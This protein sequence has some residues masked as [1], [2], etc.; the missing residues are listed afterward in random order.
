MCIVS[1]AV[2]KLGNSRL[3]CF[4]VALAHRS[5]TSHRAMHSLTVHPVR[6]SGW[7][8][9]FIL[10]RLCLPH[11]IADAS[12]KIR[13]PPQAGRSRDAG[14][15]NE[16]SMIG[17]QPGRK[18]RHRPQLGELPSA[19]VPPAKWD[20]ELNALG[21]QRRETGPAHGNNDGFPGRVAIR[22]AFQHLT[23]LKRFHLLQL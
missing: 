15:C 5:N 12:P 2:H 20:S 8:N 10:S 14:R 19:K 11:A 21:Q 6:E 3:R 16:P 23:S 17:S 1:L 22:I 4:G 9:L 7:L 13:G 18:R